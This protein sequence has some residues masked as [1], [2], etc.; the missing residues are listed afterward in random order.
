MDSLSTPQKDLV[1]AMQNAK[2]AMKAVVAEKMHLF[3]SAGKA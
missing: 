3:G 2:E 1:H